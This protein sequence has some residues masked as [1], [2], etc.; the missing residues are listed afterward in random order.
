MRPKRL[1]L[2]LSVQADKQAAATGEK[3]AQHEFRKLDHVRFPFF[4]DVAIQ[5]LEKSGVPIR[6]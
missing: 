1:V 6:P 5:R 3:G 2:D 4:D